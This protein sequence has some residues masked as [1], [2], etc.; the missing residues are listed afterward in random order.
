MSKKKIDFE[1][2][3]I[4]FQ[5][6]LVLYFLMYTVSVLFQDGRSLWSRIIFT[7]MTV[8]IGGIFLKNYGWKRFVPIFILSLILTIL[9]CL[10]MTNKTPL[11]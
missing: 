4:N 7:G 9:T 10:F 3:F 6:T 8:L 2:V 11:F 5:S 1:K